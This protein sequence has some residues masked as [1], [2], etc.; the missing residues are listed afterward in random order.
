MPQIRLI[1]RL[2]F[3]PAPVFDLIRLFDNIGGINS[4]SVTRFVG[5]D[6]D[7]ESRRL[8]FRFNKQ[9]KS[10]VFLRYIIALAGDDDEG[11][12]VFPGEHVWTGVKVPLF[13]VAA[14][15]DTVNPPAEVKAIATW[16]TP[17]GTRLSVSNQGSYGTF[18]DASAQRKD[19]SAVPTVAGDAQLAADQLTSVTRDDPP[20]GFDTSAAGDVVS[21]SHTSTHRFALKTTVFPEPASHGLLYATSTTRVLSGLIQNFIASH[22]DNRLDLGWQLQHLTTSG[23]WDVKNL[24]KWQTVL[25]C[26]EPIAGVFRAMKTMREI[27]ETHNPTEFV[28]QYGYRVIPDGV[29]MVIDISHDPPVYDPKG[30]EAAGIEYHKF[31]TVSKLPPSSDEVSHFINFI[32]H[33]R[34]SPKLAPTTENSSVHPVLGVHCHYGY[35]RTGYFI[36]CYMVERLG[37]RLQDAVEEFAQKKAPG[38][39]HEHFI[40]ELFVRYAVNLQRRGTIVE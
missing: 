7:A 33:L 23:K 1:K 6:A 39:K 5:K 21:R 4:A 28:K 10:A 30:L 24:A 17:N 36:V 20:T 37:Y 19:G 16:L 31:P 27:D 11:R 34:E 8:Q 29:A 14:E 2:R 40:N 18:D 38:I 12:P 9:S 35:N 13:L 3:L 22:I 32:D 25:P 26:T 15:S